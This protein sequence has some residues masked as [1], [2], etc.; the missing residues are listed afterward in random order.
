[1]IRRCKFCL[2]KLTKAG[3]WWVH[4]GAIWDTDIWPWFDSNA[5]DAGQM[6]FMMYQVDARWPLTR[7][8]YKA[9]E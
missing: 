7:F 1:M 9:K 5:A 3:M 2:E 6:C 4:D 8:S